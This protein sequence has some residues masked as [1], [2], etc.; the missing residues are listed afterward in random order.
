MTFADFYCFKGFHAACLGVMLSVLSSVCA[1]G[2]ETVDLASLDLSKMQQD[3]GSPGVNRSVD[4]HDLS[5]AGRKFSQG[6]GTHL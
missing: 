4:G 3:W 6:V 5:I 2:T 1:W